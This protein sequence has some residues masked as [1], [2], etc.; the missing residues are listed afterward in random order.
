[1]PDFFR[2]IGMEDIIEKEKKYLPSGEK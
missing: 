1:M 2:F